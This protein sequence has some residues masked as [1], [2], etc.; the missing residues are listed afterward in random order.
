MKKKI[1]IIAK[2]EVKKKRETLNL[3]KNSLLSN[4]INNNQTYNYEKYLKNDNRL[5][6]ILKRLNPNDDLEK[7]LLTQMKNY[8]FKK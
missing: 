3:L 7:I 5:I 1:E 4:N 8:P 6:T 2:E